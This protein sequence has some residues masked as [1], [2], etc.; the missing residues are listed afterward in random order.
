MAKNL[1]LEEIYRLLDEVDEALEFVRGWTLPHIDPIEIPNLPYIVDELSGYYSIY[2]S[3]LPSQIGIPAT[4]LQQLSARAGKRSMA[5]HTALVVAER[6]KSFLRAQESSHASGEIVVT[7]EEKLDG[8]EIV[9]AIPK[10]SS[11]SIPAERWV[12][13]PP[14]A[15]IQE[16]I[17]AVAS[18][19]E[20]VLLQLAHSN[21]PENDQVIR[22]LERA[23]LIAILETALNVL[24]SPAIESGLMKKVADRLTE[25]AKKAAEKQIQEGLGGMM[26]SVADQLWELVRQLF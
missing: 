4:T 13:V 1:S 26:Q 15:D 9:E 23:Q 2:S 14:S 22:G 18:L 6:L 24:R 12:I 17:R 20:T 10:A 3:D 25:T 8:S 16:R 21:L 7:T 19:L 5:T 11:P